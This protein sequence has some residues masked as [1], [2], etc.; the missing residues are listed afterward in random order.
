LNVVAGYCDGKVIGEYC[1]TGSTTSAMFE[2]WFCRFLLPET[3]KG[4]T[5]IMDNARY[6]NKKRLRLYAWAYKVTIIFL[7]PYSPDYNVIEHVWFN[8]K[9]FLG[10]TALK[11]HS[12]QAAVYWYFT[13]AFYLVE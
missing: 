10:D 2:D 13:M 6:H 3:S 7:P 11:F 12:L 1:Y 4:D 9:R 8:L 5:V